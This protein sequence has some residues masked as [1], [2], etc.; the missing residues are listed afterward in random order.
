MKRFYWALVI[1]I[2]CHGLL[3]GIPA[4]DPKPEPPSGSVNLAVLQPESES[5]PPEI[6]DFLGLHNS[7]GGGTRTELAP[8]SAR[9]SPAGIQT[10]LVRDDRQASPSSAEPEAPERDRTVTPTAPSDNPGPARSEPSKPTA[11]PRQEPHP[12]AEAEPNP[13]PEMSGTPQG[14]EDPPPRGHEL[15]ARI[16]DSGSSRADRPQSLVV[17][18]RTRYGPAAAYLADWEKRVEAVGNLN[19]PEAAR[20]QD[21]TGELMLRVTVDSTGHVE[22]LRVLRSSGEPILDR[23]AE[24]IV[25]LAA[26]FPA[27]SEALREEAARLHIIRRWRFTLAHRLRGG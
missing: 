4:G 22:D 8:E 11:H 1:A 24:R 7:Q 3:L 21:L 16:G 14:T 10:L 6:A 26:P 25:E 18:A 20:R 2:A 23:A 19:Y 15:L 27:F 17:T 5:P 12:G 9:P 13:S